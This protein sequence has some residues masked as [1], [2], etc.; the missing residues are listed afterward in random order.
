MT[1]LHLLDN[2]V[3]LFEGEVVSAFF[4]TDERPLVG[5]QALLDWRLNGLLTQMLLEG[6]ARGD[7]GEHV[8]VR[9]NGKIAADWILFLGGGERSGLVP[10][11]C[12]RLLDHLFVVCRRA[13][14]VRVALG[15]GLPEGM[16]ASSLQGLVRTALE[17]AAPAGLECLLGITDDNTWLV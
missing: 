6:S 15:L 5:P 1:H 11:R 14:F 13:G 10:E 2:P 4:F 8:L 9:S 3:D 17:A 7:F 16:S 12:R